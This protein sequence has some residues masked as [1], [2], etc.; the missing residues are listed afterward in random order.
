MVVAAVCIGAPCSG[1]AHPGLSKEVDAL[2]EKLHDAPR[3][4]ELRLRRAAA[5]RR[6]EHFDDALADVRVALRSDPD[7]AEARLERALV[8]VAQGRDKAALADLDVVLAGDAPSS[9]AWAA[10]ARVHAADKRY[11]AARHDYDRALEQ[12]AHPDYFLER[13]RVDEAREAWDDAAS[14]YREGVER[15]GAIVLRIALVDVERKRGDTAAALTEVDALLEQVPT[16]V[17]W[18]LLRAEILAESGRAEAATVER[19]RALALAHAAVARRP[20]E[21]S[22]QALAAT[23]RALEN[24]E[25]LS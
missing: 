22:R 25:P 17:D 12:R 11:E 19:L 4:V 13:G 2:T 6:L 7:H 23:Y 9:V 18:V 1:H 15:S 8:R 5:Y 16:R 14:G 21:V 10:R 3:D 20:T 24:T